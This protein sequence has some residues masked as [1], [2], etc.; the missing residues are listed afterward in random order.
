MKISLGAAYGMHA[1]MFMVR[2]I[3]QLPTTSTNI[4][5]A[6]GIPAKYLTKILHRLSVA[7]IIKVSKGTIKGYSFAKSPKQIS[8]L[9][10]LEAIEGRPLFKECFMKHCACGGTQENCVVYKE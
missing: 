7:N 8:L 2:H 6:E 3:T 5:K 9:D 1:L 4:A 10:V